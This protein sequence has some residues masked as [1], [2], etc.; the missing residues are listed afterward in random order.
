VLEKFENLKTRKPLKCRKIKLSGSAI[1]AQGRQVTRETK[2]AD[3][4]REHDGRF[5]GVELAQSAIFRQRL[6]LPSESRHA[7]LKKLETYV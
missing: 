6:R 2:G 7:K 3:A 4:N 5:I 1:H